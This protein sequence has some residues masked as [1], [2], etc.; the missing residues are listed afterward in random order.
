MSC[1]VLLQGVILI[2]KVRSYIRILGILLSIVGYFSVLSQ[3]ITD[4]NLNNSDY[5]WIF[6]N[7]FIF[8]PLVLSSS[9]LGHVPYFISTR[10]PKSLEDSTVNAEKNFKEFSFESVTGAIFFFII[11]FLTYYYQ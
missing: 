11:I 3:L 5:F 9:I 8:L 6:F 2:I 10:I 4:N 1:C 7:S